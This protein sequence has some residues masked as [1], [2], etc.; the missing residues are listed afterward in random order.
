M[1]ITQTD[2]QIELKNSGIGQ[3]FL[4]LVFI[5]SGV[6]VS[7]ITRSPDADGKKAP[8]W[9]LLIGIAVVIGG[10]AMI[11]FAKN[12]SVTIRKGGDTTVNTKRLIGGG[13]QQATI[14]TANIVAVRLSTYLDN[15]SVNDGNGGIG[16]SNQNSRRSTL[17]L[18]LNNN[19]LVELGSSGQGGLNINGLNVSSLISK[20]PLSKEAD[21]VARFLG[22]PLQADDSSSIA[23]AV[24]SLKTAFS[25]DPEP[26]PSAQ[27]P[28]FSPGQAPQAAPPPA[29]PAPQTPLPPAIPPQAPQ[30]PPSAENPGGPTAPPPPYTPQQ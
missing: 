11:I 20:A 15:N 18:V 1:K 21:Q 8:F 6:G 27:T 5:V 10:I 3:A 22:V 29:S 30:Q 17:S 26:S 28:T 24:K 12:R 23:G 25:Q 13:P 7:L 14:P 16:S 2:S 9:V 19:D 4:G